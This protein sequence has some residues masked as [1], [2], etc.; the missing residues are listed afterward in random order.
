MQE[1]FDFEDYF[2]RS[3]QKVDLKRG[4]TN[5]V[6]KKLSI[7]FHC[8]ANWKQQSVIFVCELYK[9]FFEMVN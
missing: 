5:R 6:C 4:Q 1:N 9:R 2:Y 3:E 8:I 7:R